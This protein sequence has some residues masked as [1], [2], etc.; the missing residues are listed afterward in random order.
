[1]V[2]IGTLSSRTSIELGRM[3][4]DA[5]AKAVLLPMPY[6]FSYEQADLRAFVTRV[7]DALPVPVLL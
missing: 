6:F 5:G 3:A 1:V 7:A 2:G 4:A